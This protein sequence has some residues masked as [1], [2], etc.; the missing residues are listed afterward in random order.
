M[1]VSM[2]ML[3]YAMKGLPAGTAYAIWTGI[4]A[5]GTAIFWYYRFGESANIY[6]LL[7]LAM[8]AFG[9]IGLKLA[10]VNFIFTQFKR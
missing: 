4:G 7:S 9:I 1:I 2:G 8:I 3:S 10:R 6:R 5:V